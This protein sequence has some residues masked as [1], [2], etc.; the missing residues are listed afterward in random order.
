MSLIFDLFISFR[1]LFM[2]SNRRAATAF[3]E[4]GEKRG[5]D[6]NA[7]RSAR[8]GRYGAA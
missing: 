6:G 7:I 5:Q 2:L 4:F 8:D 3:G 1:K